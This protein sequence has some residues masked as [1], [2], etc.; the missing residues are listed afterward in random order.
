MALNL[1]DRVVVWD[2]PENYKSKHDRSRNDKVEM[3][4]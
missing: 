2:I 3:L 1:R 4:K